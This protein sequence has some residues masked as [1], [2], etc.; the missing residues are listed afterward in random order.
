MTWLLSF[1]PWWAYLIAAITLVVFVQATFGW[2]AAIG[3]MIGL[4]PVLGYLWGSKRQS[5]IDRAKRDRE[6]ADAMRRRREVDDEVASMG[7]QSVAEELRRWNR[8]RIED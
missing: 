5:E 3:A 6:A 8:D 2:R 4:L 7:E 1:I